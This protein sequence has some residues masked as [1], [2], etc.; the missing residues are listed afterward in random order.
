MSLQTEGS[1]PP[2]I[3]LSPALSFRPNLLACSLFGV[4]HLM[5][6]T[7][8][9]EAILLN[10]PLRND[11]IQWSGVFLLKEDDNVAALNISRGMT[12]L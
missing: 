9:D 3:L 1:L 12:L 7:H 6:I 2:N 10:M 4:F 11:D 8:S 5:C